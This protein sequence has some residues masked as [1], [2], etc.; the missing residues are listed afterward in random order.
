MERH[1]QSSLRT[2]G[3]N[4]SPQ[5]ATRSAEIGRGAYKYALGH[6]VDAPLNSSINPHGFVLV[7]F[8]PITFCTKCA[9][10]QRSPN[11]SIQPSVSP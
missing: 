1:F 9:T 8:V 11:N 3:S 6:H 4:P 2:E 7:D 5:K 10:A